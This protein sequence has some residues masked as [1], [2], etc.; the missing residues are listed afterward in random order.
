MFGLIFVRAILEYQF[1]DHLPYSG[2]FL[3]GKID[4]LDI[5]IIS[6]NTLSE[7]IHA[8]KHGAS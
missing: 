7:F 1:S 2:I 4:I 3:K 5:Q 6:E 8:Y